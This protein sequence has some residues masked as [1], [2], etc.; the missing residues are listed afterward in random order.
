MRACS[1]SKS[2]AS[3][4]GLFL[5]AVATAVAGRGSGGQ[6]PA[7]AAGSRRGGQKGSFHGVVPWGARLARRGAVW[8]QERRSCR[9]L[10][11]RPNCRRRFP[12]NGVQQVQHAHFIQQAKHA[13]GLFR[14]RKADAAFRAED[15]ARFGMQPGS[16]K[17]NA[18]FARAQGMEDTGH[19]PGVVTVAPANQGDDP[20][21]SAKACGGAASAAGIRA[22]CASRLSTTRPSW[23]S[24]A[25]SSTNRGVPAAA[26][27]AWP[28]RQNPA[29]CHFRATGGDLPRCDAARPM[30]RTGVMRSDSRSSTKRTE[31][32]PDPGGHVPDR[33]SPD[34]RSPRGGEVRRDCPAADGPRRRTAASCR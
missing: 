8:E 19:G 1:S 21:T 11:E 3:T 24:R 18:P 33:R 31:G 20:H 2:L 15:I 32:A 12:R 10:C 6:G 25:V 29:R 23:R 30:R 14:Q 13:A 34:C 22:D 26:R 4:L 7:A 5:R 27:P 9:R 16:G 28:V 17:D